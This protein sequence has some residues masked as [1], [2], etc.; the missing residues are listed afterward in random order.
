MNPGRD[1]LKT[2]DQSTKRRL[3]VFEWGTQPLFQHDWV[4]EFLMSLFVLRLLN[5]GRL[6]N[7]D[8]FF[9]EGKKLV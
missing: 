8:Y 4:L 3:F 6:M 5:L 9:E 7:E 2:L 1:C